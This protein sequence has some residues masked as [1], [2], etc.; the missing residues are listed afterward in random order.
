MCEIVREA[1]ISTYEG[2]MYR[3]GDASLLA[4]IAAGGGGGL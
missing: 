2:G 3:E 4:V 1:G